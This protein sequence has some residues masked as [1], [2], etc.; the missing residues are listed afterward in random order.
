MLKKIF[1]II[2]KIIFSVLVLY[3][4]N[5]ISSPLNLMVPI[6]IITVSLISILGMPALFALILVLLLVF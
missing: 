4:Y 3:G 5:L 6:N 2:K 1:E